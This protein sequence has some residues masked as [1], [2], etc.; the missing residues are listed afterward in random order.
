MVC[1]QTEEHFLKHGLPLWDPPKGGPLPG[2]EVEA[3]EARLAELSGAEAK[4]AKRGRRDYE[5]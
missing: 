3:W 2:E 1:P 5:K 4:E